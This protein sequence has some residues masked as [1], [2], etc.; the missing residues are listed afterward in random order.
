MIGTIV[1]FG[2]LGFGI[3]FIGLKK[4]WWT[5]PTTPNFTW[6]HWATKILLAILAAGAIWFFWGDIKPDSAGKP[7]ETTIVVYDLDDNSSIVYAGPCPWEGGENFR[8]KVTPE[9][10]KIVSVSSNDWDHAII[11]T[12]CDTGTTKFPSRHEGVP[13]KV[14]AVK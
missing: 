9:C 12:G 2:I 7:K 3:F 8:V 1:F 6:P 5:T 10:G 13:V 4:G 11:L 14:S